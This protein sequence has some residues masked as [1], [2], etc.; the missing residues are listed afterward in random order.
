MGIGHME[1]LKYYL[2]TIII[3]PLDSIPTLCKRKILTL[4]DPGGISNI[5][6]LMG[7]HLESTLQSGPDTLRLLDMTELDI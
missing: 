7:D 4:L 5:V 1:R 3:N 2:T 6:E